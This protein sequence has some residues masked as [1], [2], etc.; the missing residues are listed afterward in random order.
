MLLLKQ[1]QK[2]PGKIM[3]RNHCC[4][5][6]GRGGEREEGRSEDFLIVTQENL[7]DPPIRF[8]NS[9]DSPPPYALVVN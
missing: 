5:L 2:P 3:P 4:L 1:M 8:C 6:I 9:H 7:P